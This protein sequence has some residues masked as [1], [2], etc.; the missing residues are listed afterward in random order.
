V[1]LPIDIAPSDEAAPPRLNGELQF[2]SPWQGRAFGMCLALLER[3][4]DGW[5]AFRS[6]LVPQLEA[7]PERAYYDSFVLALE[8]YAGAT[9]RDAGERAARATPS[10]SP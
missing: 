2:E 6:H 4:G 10:T 3:N 1:T 7:D 9:A 5:D 8:S